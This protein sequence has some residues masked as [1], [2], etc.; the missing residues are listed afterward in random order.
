MSDEE[1]EDVSKHGNEGTDH[2]RY[3]HGLSINRGEYYDHLPDLDQKW[4]DGVVDD[5]LDKSRY[6]PESLTALEKCRQ[7]AIDLHQRRRADGYIARKGLT[8]EK[9]VGFHE[10]YGEINETQ[11]NVLMI[12]KDRLSRESRLAMK[13]LG[14]LDEDSGTSN[15]EDSSFMEK[16][17]RELEDEED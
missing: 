12:T 4:I 9:T 17:S 13:D 7:I 10:Q 11:E 8:Q 1:E 15:G 5:L 2:P 6:T 16:L 3:E 14:I